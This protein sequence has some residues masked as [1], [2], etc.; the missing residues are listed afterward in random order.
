MPL[1]AQI[2]EFESVKVTALY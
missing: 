2:R 1:C